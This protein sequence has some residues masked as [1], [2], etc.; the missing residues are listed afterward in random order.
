ML[1]LNKVYVA[2]QDKRGVDELE[3]RVGAQRPNDVAWIARYVLY[4]IKPSWQTE[5]SAT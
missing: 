5:T 4:L 3:R 1:Y 2:L